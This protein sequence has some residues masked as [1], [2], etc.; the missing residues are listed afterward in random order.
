MQDH[1]GQECQILAEKSV[2]SPWQLASNFT[3]FR[4][5][6][7]DPVSAGGLLFLTVLEVKV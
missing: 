1:A 2:E 4:I 6:R 5:L 7:V 3:W